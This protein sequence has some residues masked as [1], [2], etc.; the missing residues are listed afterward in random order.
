LIGSNLLVFNE[1]YDMNYTVYPAAFLFQ[2][3]GV[4]SV[5]KIIMLF[6]PW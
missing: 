1:N 2:Q 5:K 3:Y 4:V 6:T